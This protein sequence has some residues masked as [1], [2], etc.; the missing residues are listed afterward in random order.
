[1][2]VRRGLHVRKDAVAGTSPEDARLAQAG[3]VTGAGDL[4]VVP[5]VLS[6]CVVSGTAG[7][8]YSIGAG[9]YVTTRGASDGA[10]F[11]TVDGAT[12]APPT[13]TVAVAPATGSRYDLIWVMQRDV[14]EGDADSQAVTGVTS[15]TASGSPSKPYG[16][17]PAGALVLAEARVYAGAPQTSDALVTITQ[18]AAPVA[19]RG[20]VVPVSSAAV[21]DALGTA[22]GASTPLVYRTDERIIERRIAAGTWQ[23][24]TGAITGVTSVPAFSLPSAVPPATILTSTVLTHPFTGEVVVSA[25]LVGDAVIGGNSSA[26]FL[27]TVNGLARPGWT[28]NFGAGLVRDSPNV[29]VTTTVAAGT[30]VSIQVSVADVGAG[31]TSA[32]AAS[33]QVEWTIRPGRG[34][35]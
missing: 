2:A 23:S 22:A 33:L 32:A 4:A 24:V 16:S 28:Q 11:G 35:A 31:G 9:H 13:G 19:A 21:R 29:H 8:T 18:V 34:A 3:L 10:V 12:V 7:W 30:P 6:G 20:G 17:V 27:L 1:M 15:G 14:D 26:R 25:D 5:G